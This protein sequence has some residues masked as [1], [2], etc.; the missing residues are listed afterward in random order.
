[1]IRTHFESLITQLPEKPDKPIEISEDGE[2]LSIPYASHFGLPERVLLEFGGRNS[3]VP[4][5]DHTLRPYIAEKVPELLYPEAQVVVLSPLRTFWEKVTLIHVACTR[6]DPRLDANRQ[7]RHWHDLAVLADH[8]I[9]KSAIADRE[10]LE[11]VVKYK[12]V[13]FRAGYAHYEDCLSGG[14]RLVP[15]TPLLEA[16]KIDYEKMIADGMFDGQPPSFDKIITRLT[17]LAKEINARHV[18]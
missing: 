3:I 13:F 9:G 5:K 11:D 2:T 17:D 14:L 16:L 7:S 18:A 1:L 12:S 6:A 10:L 8:D 4:N 15:A